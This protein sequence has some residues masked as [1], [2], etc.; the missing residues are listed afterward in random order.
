MYLEIAS[1]NNG[2]SSYN[3]FVEEKNLLPYTLKHR[4][5]APAECTIPLRDP[6]GALARKYDVADNDVYGGTGI[7]VLEDPDETD[8]FIGRIMKVRHDS[9]VNKGTTYLY[10]YDL[11]SQMDEK[12]RDYDMREELDEDRLRESAL[13]SDHTEF[14]IPVDKEISRAKLF[15]GAAY[16]DQTAE[17]NEE[18]D[19]D[20]TFLGAAPAVDDYYYFGWDIQVPGM[21]VDIT[22]NGNWTGS[23]LWEYYDGGAWVALG[24]ID[25]TNNKWAFESGVG[26]TSYAWAVPGDWAQVAVDGFTRYWIRATVQVYTGAVV[27]PQARRI[28]G[29]HYAWDHSQTFGNNEFNGKFLVFTSGN[30]GKITINHGVFDEEY[31]AGGAVVQDNPAAGERNLWI[32]DANH[33]NLEDNNNANYFEWRYTFKTQLHDNPLLVADSMDG[34][35]LHVVYEL[36][37]GVGKTSAIENTVMILNADTGVTYDAVYE[38]KMDGG[39]IETV[40]TIP[41]AVFATMIDEDNGEV[42]VHFNASVNAAD[43]TELNVYYLR[44]LTDVEMEGATEAY[45]IYDTLPDYLVVDT[46][47]TITGEGLF[48]GALYS[49]VNFIYTHINGLVTANSIHAD[50]ALTSSVESTTGLTT[51]NYQ[52][53]TDLEIV[54]DLCRMDRAVVWTALGTKQVTYKRTFNAGA[55]VAMTDANVLGWRNCEYDYA[56]MKNHWIVTGVRIGDN[57]LQTDSTELATDP[58]DTSQAKF[59]VHRTGVMRSAGTVSQYETDQLATALVN[60]DSDVLYFLMAELAGRDDT[61]RLGT[62][63]SITSSHLGLTAE[64]YVVTHWIY[65]ADTYRTTIRL[66]PRSSVGYMNHLLGGDFMFE[67]MQATATQG[68]NQRSIGLH[69]TRW[70]P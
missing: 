7:V 65:N 19:D 55:P 24:I 26:V 58:G 30:V 61:Y 31:F 21:A 23:F 42:I 16:T 9:E 6:D 63:V 12:R 35:R 52:G 43:T 41:P 22:T 14:M 5:G 29:Q 62:E 40:I 47:L 11:M 59:A 20:V 33:H 34:A 28:W 37:G 64:K 49:I 3:A 56:L 27:K 68:I 25:P 69:T 38:L 1:Y 57:V 51:R 15:S 66:H 46:D 45:E 54:N 39:L 60:R 2:A 8:I 17:A 53:F 44:L 13:Q 18:T 36:I 10:C 50:T 32:N 70:D 48:E 4:F 67:A